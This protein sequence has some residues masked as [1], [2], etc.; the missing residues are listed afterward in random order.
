MFGI[1]PRLETLE[2]LLKH[3]ICDKDRRIEEL[4]RQLENALTWG[5]KARQKAK[6]LRKANRELRGEPNFSRKPVA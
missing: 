1:N 6:H 2:R 3:Q 5:R 4:E